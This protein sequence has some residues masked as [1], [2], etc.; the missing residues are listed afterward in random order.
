VQQTDSAFALVA[1]LLLT[2]LAAFGLAYW[3]Y[4]ARTDRSAR[5]GLYLLFG[6]PGGLLLVAG[7]AT[8]VRNDPRLGA[9]LLAIGLALALPLLK[10][11]RGVL[12]RVL[13]LDP[14]SPMDMAGLAVVLVVIAF[15]GAPLLFPE[16]TAPPDPSLI[17]AIGYLELIAQGLAFLAIAYLSVG[18]LIPRFDRERNVPTVRTLG[19]ATARLGIAFPDWRT[20]AI[21]VGAIVPCFL[22]A[23]IAGAIGVQLQPGL[24][25]G[26]NEVVD[27]MTGAVQTI[28][29]AIVLGLSAGIGEEAIFR[30]ALQPR[31]G[32][33]LTSLCF[34]LLH[35]GQYGLNVAIVGLLLVSIVLGLERKYVNTTAAM[36]THALFN[37]IQVAALSLM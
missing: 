9:L 10:P 22:L 3:S 33:G 15:N 1:A 34:A 26:L 30:G 7:L 24:D 27:Q 12:G 8:L 2:V 13:P 25:E 5:V 32:I 19:E 20:V 14:D 37:A 6:I 17:P 18:W 35:G 36:I 31:L 4:R 23:G 21:G 16:A 28:P 11:V 29:G